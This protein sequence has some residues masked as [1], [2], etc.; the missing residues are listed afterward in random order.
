[1]KKNMGSADRWIRFFLAA[2]AVILY[3]THVI[4]GTVGLIVIVIA[5]VFLLTSFVGLCPLYSLFG[6][7]T[8][9]YKKG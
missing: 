1:M 5:G 4:T 2:M 6:I 9:G 3:F 7:N 8:C